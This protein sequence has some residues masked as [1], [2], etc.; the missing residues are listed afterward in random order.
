VEFRA[1]DV[2]FEA[3][4]EALK[5]GVSEVEAIAVWRRP[6]TIDIVRGEVNVARSGEGLALG[7]RVA[8]GRRVAVGGGSVRAPGDVKSIVEA[9]VRIARAS[10]EDPNWRGLPERIS[11]SSAK[12]SYDA[13]LEK[14]DVGGLVKEMLEVS[15]G[16][17]GGGLEVAGLQLY[18]V[19]SERALSNTSLDVL[20]ERS[21]RVSGY[22]EVKAVESGVQSICREYHMGYSLGEFK[23]EDL[24]ENASRRALRGLRTVS[25]EPG[26]Y[27]V[28]LSPKVTAGV[29]NAIL[30][31]AVTADNV[32]RG[33]SPLAGKLNNMVLGEGVTITDDPTREGLYSTTSFDDEGVATRAKTI[34]RKGVLETFLYDTYTAR[35]EG[36]E[37]TGNA[38]RPGV[39]VAPRPAPL[40]LIMEGGSESFD[41]LLSSVRRGLV[42]YETIGEWL[43]NPVSGHLNATVTYGELIEDGEF[44]GVVR[45]VVISGNFYNLFKDNIE[46]LSRELDNMYNV[47]TPAVMLRD[48]TISSK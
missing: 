16:L 18:A 5:L 23:F 46:G 11:A 9:V 27:T 33:R 15:R 30:S 28:V 20:E 12:S 43:S 14:L 22:V 3:V 2:A 1:R 47:Y 32:Q 24:L 26:R 25:V 19:I 13:R 4:R 37:S 17:S 40:S 36:R 10:R 21:S 42:V 6:L 35:I 31:P 48:V 41:S 8:I 39:T 45:G 7:V 34:T 44:K 38:A 29:V